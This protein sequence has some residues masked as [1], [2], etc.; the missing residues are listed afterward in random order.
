MRPGLAGEELWSEGGSSGGDAMQ[1][2][3]SIWGR[4]GSFLSAF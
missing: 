3:T 4:K 2:G 1:G